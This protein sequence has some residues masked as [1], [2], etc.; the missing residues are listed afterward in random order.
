MDGGEASVADDPGRHEAVTVGGAFFLYGAVFFDRLAPLY[1]VGLV[2]ADL[3]V[4]AAWEGTLALLIG[5]G[6]AAA[7][8]LV[9]AT[10]GR[11]DDRTRITLG[12]AVAGLVGIASAAAGSWVLFVLLRGLG[13]LASASGAP[14]ITSLVFG[15]APERRRGLDLGIVQ[16]ATRIVGSLVAPV[17]VTAVAVAA[18]WR[19]AL[20]VAGVLLLVG[21]VVLA[22]VVPGRGGGVVRRSGHASFAYRPGGRRNVVLCTVGCVLLLAWLT[23]WSQSSVA[24]VRS[25]LDVDA[26]AAGR[27][28]GLFGIGAG[29]A[30]L[31][32]PVISD[33]IGRRGA[34]GVAGA[35]GGLGGL[36]VGGF[37]AADVVPPGPVL[38]VALLLAGVAMGGLPLVISIVPAEAVGTGDVGRAI[39][40]PIAG[41]ETLGSA[42]L[43]ALAA[44]AAVPLGRPTVLMLAATGVVGLVAVAAALRPLP[45]SIE[46][47]SVRA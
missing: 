7:M 40:G 37:A 42:A 13:G 9:R 10:S 8:P 33:R 28:V 16:S 6:W 4:P 36:A 23:T 5:L 34:L 14:A 32:L 29:A 19:T 18:G 25:W 46:T 31:G 2:A 39:T 11:L 24:L 45:A 3:G 38:V 41:G 17:V 47:T 27:W 1:L 22:V 26:D 35:L 21:A 30:S 43:P 15:V 12:A 20:V 44:W